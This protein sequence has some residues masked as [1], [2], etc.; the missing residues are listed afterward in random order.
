MIR[1]NPT[2]I[3]LKLEELQEFNG[4]KKEL[5]K[6]KAMKTGSAEQAKLPELP[7]SRQEVVNERSGYDPTMRVAT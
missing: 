2:R 1:R 3:E 7:K 5:E 6:K 4:I